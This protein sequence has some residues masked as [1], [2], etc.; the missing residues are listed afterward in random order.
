M[1][2]QIFGH[3]T[4]AGVQE[5]VPYI[6]AA[7]ELHHA[8][9][10]FEEPGLLS[11]YPALLLGDARCVAKIDMWG[12]ATRVAWYEIWEA[13]LAIATVCV[14]AAGKGGKAFR[15]GQYHRMLLA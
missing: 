4:D 6:I 5:E 10:M 14:R 13:V 9:T 8:P 15:L 7:G 12:S 3:P 2:R 1:D 11:L